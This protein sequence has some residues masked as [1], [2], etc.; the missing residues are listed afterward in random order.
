[1]IDFPVFFC[2]TAIPVKEA[3]L[4]NPQ[5]GLGT[6]SALQQDQTVFP[7]RAVSYQQKLLRLQI[8]AGTLEAKLGKA[9][10]LVHK[11]KVSAVFQCP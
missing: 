7:I 1:M 2:G 5:T 3:E 6:F 11:K 9:E 8:V 10:G 4:T